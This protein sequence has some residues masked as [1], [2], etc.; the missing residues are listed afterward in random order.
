[1]ENM[2]MNIMTAKARARVKTKEEIIKSSEKIKRVLSIFNLI[3]L[4]FPEDDIIDSFNVSPDVIKIIK[5]QMP[6]YTQY[7]KEALKPIYDGGEGLKS[8][9][10]KIESL[11]DL[12]NCYA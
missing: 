1:M 3:S 8:C 6:L 5:R 12:V 4:G 2:N 11:S 7:K 10:E 9:R